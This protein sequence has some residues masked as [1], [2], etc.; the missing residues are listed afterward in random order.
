MPSITVPMAVGAVILGAVQTAASTVLEPHVKRAH[1]AIRTGLARFLGGFTGKIESGPTNVGGEPC[2]EECGAGGTCSATRELGGLELGAEWNPM[3]Y[4]EWAA[5]RGPDAKYEDYQKYRQKYGAWY[6]AHVEIPRRKR[7]QA[8]AQADIA[9]QQAAAAQTARDTAA[10]ERTMNEKSAAALH[11]RD[12]QDAYNAKIQALQVQL[13]EQKGADRVKTQAEL[14]KARI[15]RD[16]AARA[17]GPGDQ[18]L[19]A[20]KILKELQPTPA[21]AA[22][23][24]APVAMYPTEDAVVYEPSGDDDIVGD[25]EMSFFGKAVPLEYSGVAEER[26]EFIGCAPCGR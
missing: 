16:L 5:V 11:Q 22:P 23:A 24:A 26:P 10:R 17:P 1:G 8:Q 3:R 14:A 2:C 19:E 13:A 9:A 12:V 7:E 6:A 20:V 21:A 15:G 18:L 25:E 4:D